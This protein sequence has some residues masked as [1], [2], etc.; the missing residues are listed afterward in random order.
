MLNRAR[1]A[2]AAAVADEDDLEILRAD[3]EEIAHR[4]TG[5]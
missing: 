1:R 4:L 5:L 2:K 3:V